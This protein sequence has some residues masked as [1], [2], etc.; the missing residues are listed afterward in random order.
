MKTT[1]ELFSQAQNQ[2][3]DGKPSAA[4]ETLN[5]ALAMTPDDPN[6]LRLL[7]LIELEKSNLDKS[8]ELLLSLIHI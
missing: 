6:S 2:L 8:V 4:T 5:R 3:R 7:G 1:K